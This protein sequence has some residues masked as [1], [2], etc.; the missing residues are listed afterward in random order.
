MPPGK[1]LPPETIAEFERW[2]TNGA[3]MP[4]A[5]PAPAARLSTQR[6]WSLVKV[7]K[8]ALPEVKQL[9]WVANDVDRFVLAKLESKQLRPNPE[10]DKRTLIRRLSYDL[11]G[12]PPTAA[13]VESFVSDSSKNAYE[14]LVDRLLA[15]PRY[16][17]RWGRYWLDVARY[18]DSRN[19]GDRFAFSYTYRDWVIR[20]LNED[21]PY[22]QFLLQQLAA[23]LL[24][25]NKRSN[26][27]ALGFLSLGREFPKS[28][29]ETVDDRIDTVTR[30]MLGLTVACARCHD[31]KY[32]P[33]PTKDYYSLYS[34][35]SNIREP[36][37]LPALEGSAKV[38]QSA[39]AAAYERDLERIRNIDQEYR[40]RRNAEMVKFFK[41]QIA[42]YLMA[43]HDSRNL[44]NT[45]IEEL[46][47]DRQLNLHLLGRWRRY[48]EQSRTSG[49]PVFAAWHSLSDIGDAQFETKAE[50]ALASVQGNRLVL[51]AL[52]AQRPQ[53]LRQVAEIYAKVLLEHDVDAPKDADSRALR[54]VLKGATSP[55][56]LPVEEFELIYTEGD[57]NNTRA[58]RGRYNTVLAM[59]AYD[60][61]S[62]RAMSL[63]D[64]PDPKV[65]HVF[66]RG[67]PNNPGV[68]AP[69]HFLSC[70]SEGE[71]AVYQ[72]GSGR[73]E[74]AQNIASAENPLTARVAVNRIWMHH[75]GAGLVRTPS[76]YGLRGDPPTH[77]ELLDYLAATFV[78]NGWSMKKLHR[79]ILLSSTYRQSSVD[80]AEARKVD[81]ENQWLWRM[82]RRRLDVESL[83]DSM[84][85]AAG[86]LDLTAGGA[87]YSLT[88]QPSVPRRTVYGFVERGRIPGLLSVFDFA[89][90]DTHAPLR[91]NTTVPQQAL[92]LLNSPFVTEQ[93]KAL[94][95][96]VASVSGAEQK[97]TGLFELALGRKPTAEEAQ[98]G[99]QFTASE[100]GGPDAVAEDSAWRYG[101]GSFD[102]VRGTTFNHFTTFTGDNWQ[103]ASMLPARDAGKARLRANGGEPGFDASQAVI[104]R[105]VSPV[106]GK[107]MLTGTLRHSQS[108]IPAGDG[109]RARI[110]S[111][112]RGELASYTLND[113]GAE[114]KITNLKV[115][116]GETIDFIVE[117]LQDSENDNFNWAVNVQGDQQTWSAPEEFAGPKPVPLKT[118][119]RYAQVLL[120]TNEFAFV[121]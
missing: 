105:W 72:R 64:V 113:Q 69:P 71:P 59:Y 114:T 112:S 100:V 6:H 87:P 116:K 44:T 29:P 117:P 76:D 21:M 115:K 14:R 97:V 94:A 11:I 50:P 78:E 40:E 53:S 91:Y 20:A 88:A 81:P 39:R 52:R 36:L 74:L 8:P 31:H 80:N 46:V 65:A 110:V 68:E 92:F 73:L 104:R 24:P 95:A 82:N 33:I 49:E 13:E 118:W 101:W 111:S 34:V 17:E 63:E 10:A 32:D 56:D 7:A 79:L 108:A 4:E 5:S 89:S 37:D 2:V 58:F 83:R 35:F 60:G 96:R 67:N 18:S 90:P 103:N 121:D 86:R 51:T 26:L 22:D 57:G 62:G 66:M 106:D 102:P 41:G 75:F 30:G 54:A 55:V 27:A 119:E 19:A 107:V 12:L 61:A 120:L 70:L 77:P 3:P 84:L 45:G 47:R 28:F 93:A 38:A 99:I 1:A 9:D 23:D 25:Q 42:D 98:A 85:M 48:L 15:S 43:A 109:I 16:G